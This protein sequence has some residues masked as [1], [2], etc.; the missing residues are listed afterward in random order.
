MNKEK[1]RQEK[2]KKACG[3]LRGALCFGTT[4]VAF[5]GSLKILTSSGCHLETV[6][7]RVQIKHFNS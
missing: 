5:Y 4:T 1:T 3:V 2:G 7:S 6:R